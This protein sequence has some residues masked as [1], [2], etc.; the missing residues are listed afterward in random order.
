MN[1]SIKLSYA[2]FGTLLL[3]A[4]L[5]VGILFYIADQRIENLIDSSKLK[6]STLTISQINKEYSD[7]KL[8]IYDY[9]TISSNSL[10]DIKR[11]L[12]I[13][14][15]KLN[16]THQGKLALFFQEVDDFEDY[17]ED[18][19]EDVLNIEK[20]LQNAP[21][22]TRNQFQTT[23]LDQLAPL[24]MT[25][26]KLRI[27]TIKHSSETI[28]TEQEIIQDFFEFLMIIFT[29]VLLLLCA[30]FAFIYFQM[31][32]LMKSYRALTLTSKQLEAA[33]KTKSSFLAHIS[34]ELRTPLN[35][36]IGFSDIL[37]QEYLGKMSQK[38][39][40]DYS[41]EIYES[42]NHLLTMINDILD[43]SKID[44][45]ER[46]IHP[47]KAQVTQLIEQSIKMLSLKSDEKHITVLKDFPETVPPLYIDP[48]SIKQCLINLLSNSIKFTPE[49]GEIKVIIQEQKDSLEITISDTGIG[50]TADGIKRA[51][52]PF[53]QASEGNKYNRGSM[54]TG[55][56]LPI[57]KSLVQLNKG[58]FWITSEPDKGTNIVITL[59]L[60]KAP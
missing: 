20:T 5:V 51:L 39:Y 27:A 45:G 28:K 23:I 47:G 8:S 36:I 58:T 30:V 2:I 9:C 22:M 4:S 53:Q 49:N 42:S 32:N 14:S 25:V 38:E 31:R 11:D 29:T 26:N 55:L 24:G 41:E 52:T 21:H 34:H 35:A 37:R 19:N 16:Q 40:V 10:G 6:E 48:L 17:I 54:G 7:L 57:T 43:M 44:A 50:M 56:G 12:D 3:L 1:R 15:M 33:N 13:F 60:Y 59:P 46:E 18:I